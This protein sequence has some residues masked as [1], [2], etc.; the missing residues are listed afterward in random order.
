MSSYYDDDDEFYES[1][2]VHVY[3][4]E[5]KSSLTLTRIDQ[6]HGFQDDDSISC[7]VCGHV[8]KSFGYDLLSLTEAK[9]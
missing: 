4:P 9:H 5:C 2:E 3:C 8:F 6:K 7:P 1:E